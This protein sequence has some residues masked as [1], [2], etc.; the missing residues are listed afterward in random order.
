MLHNTF[1]LTKK[2]SRSCPDVVNYASFLRPFLLNFIPY[3]CAPESLLW[4]PE[5]TFRPF[6]YGIKNVKTVEISIK[7]RPETGL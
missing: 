3:L 6:F 1:L 4:G 5:S 2:G 7:K